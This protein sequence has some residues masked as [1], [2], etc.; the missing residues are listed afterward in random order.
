MLALLGYTVHVVD[1]SGII[2][3]FSNEPFS[4]FTNFLHVLEN[5]IFQLSL[6]K[7]VK[8]KVYRSLAEKRANFISHF[9]VLED[10]HCLYNYMYIMTR[11]VIL[12]FLVQT[13][14]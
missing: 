6:W 10:L 13:K 11:E 1:N 5:L 14:I 12:S 8:L 9:L 2:L 4:A 3:H 7:K